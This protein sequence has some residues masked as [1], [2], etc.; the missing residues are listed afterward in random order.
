MMFESLY[1]FA[2]KCRTENNKNMSLEKCK[3]CGNRYKDL[4]SHLYRTHLMSV[5]EYKKYLKDNKIS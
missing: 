3:L 5:K 1:G 2:K 4:R